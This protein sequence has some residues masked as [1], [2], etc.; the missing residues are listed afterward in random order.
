MEQLA[1]TRYSQEFRKQSV[2]FFKESGAAP[3]RTRET[4]SAKRLA[5]GLCCN[6][7]KFKVTTD[8]KHHLSFAPLIF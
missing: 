6:K 5:L 7:N 4:Y 8:S 1:R 2:K 3:Q